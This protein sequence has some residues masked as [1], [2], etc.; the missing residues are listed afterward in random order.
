MLLQ[1]SKKY[2]LS[3]VLYSS[4]LLG[5]CGDDIL[6]SFKA[7]EKAE[8]SDKQQA[9]I[10]A[11]N[12]HQAQIKVGTD[13][14]VEELTKISDVYNEQTG[15]QIVWTPIDKTK[16]EGEP[17]RFE[18]VYAQTMPD[19]DTS[20]SSGTNANST[21]QLNA[22]SEPTRIF[23]SEKAVEASG[24]IAIVDSEESDTNGANV[25]EDL[26]ET[27]GDSRTDSEDAQLDMLLMHSAY[28]L[29]AAK[30]QRVL[31]P[32]GSDWLIS[33]IPTIYQD[34]AG[35]WYGLS[36]YGRT[37]VYNKN[38][39]NAAELTTYADLA[40][41]R[42]SNRLCMTALGSAENEAIL[43]RMVPYH[44]K[45]ATPKLMAG[46][47]AN[48]PVESK[49]DND[50]LTQ[51][52]QGDCDVGLVNSDVFW[53][54]IKQYPRTPLRLTWANQNRYGVLTNSISAGV[55]RSSTQPNQALMFMEWLAS[56]G[57]QALLAFNTGTFPVATLTNTTI[58]TQVLQPDW[59]QFKA[60]VEPLISI[61][62]NK[63][64][65]RP[66]TSSIPVP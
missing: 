42:F 66:S 31:Q 18:N 39:V 57:G 2:T 7:D 1:T 53:Q 49:T 32:I 24:T 60:D 36:R 20:L 21:D 33:R 41:S 11:S 58:D 5:G 15:V 48:R 17:I 55:M 26:I 61:M 14:N 29:N 27:D 8:I 45:T 28:T 43:K 12:D 6:S 54:H 4:L 46:W 35:T 50:V 52:E 37:M 19:S 16:F 23:E 22:P 38:R 30:Q 65:L 56:D 10:L 34:P 13:L 25:T 63:M 9:D 40:S 62:N 64:T 3:I 59:A 47:I 51:I 44:G